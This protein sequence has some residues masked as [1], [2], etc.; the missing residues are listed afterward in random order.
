M[1]PEQ[2]NAIVQRIADLEDAVATLQA[3]LELATGED[4]VES[5]VEPDAFLR[6]VAG[7]FGLG[8]ACY[9]AMHARFVPGAPPD[10]Y[11]L[12]ELPPDASLD[13]ARA[14][15]RR[16]VRESHPD[17]LRARGVPDEAV[18]LAEDRLKAL[19]SAWEEVQQR[20]AA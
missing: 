20:H 17:A 2:W 19:N 9:R 8:D 14:A 3:E 15:F 10:P 11:D 12:L 4:I 5:V 1:S 13:Q 16:M 18:R 6:E 7:I